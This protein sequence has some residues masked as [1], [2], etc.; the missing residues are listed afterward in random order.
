[1]KKKFYKCYECEQ[2]FGRRWNALRHNRLIHGSAAD[3]I[4]NDIKPRTSY[5]SYNKYHN[6]QKKFEILNQAG[7]AI[8]NEYDENLSDIFDLDKEDF[9][10]MKI[11]DQ[12]IKP[13]TELEEL[14]ID[15]DPKTRA[16][17]LLR[18]FDVSIQSPNPIDPMN[19]MVELLR[20]INGIKKIAKYESMIATTTS[21]DPISEIKEKIKN[22]YLFE[23]QNN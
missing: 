11:I 10:I 15:S 17:I 22:S 20:S 16:F 14:L 8:Y 6:Y 21:L 12:L 9:K 13:F 18:S 2:K 19:E 4:S 1:M 7:I 5:M 23:R 3:I